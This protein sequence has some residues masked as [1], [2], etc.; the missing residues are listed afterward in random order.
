LGSVAI[1]AALLFGLHDSLVKAGWSAAT[2][3]RGLGGSAVVL[4]VWFLAAVALAWMG[5]YAADAKRPPRIE[6]GLLVPVTI[7]LVLLWRKSAFARLIGAVPQE[8]LVGV[9]VYR[10]LGAIFLI[11]YSM[12]KLPGVFAWPAGVGD[13]LVGV[14]APIVALAYRRAPR[15]K[16]SL[17]LAW[18]ILGLA[19]LVVAI[20]TGLLSS[21]SPIQ[22]LA[23]DAPNELI[24]TFPLALIPTF[25]VPISILLHVASLKRLYGEAY[26]RAWA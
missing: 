18:N 25:L 13:I 15:E 26:G 17:V 19:D 8:W 24:T 21:P 20:G 1:I 22:R 2:Y 9:Q 5:V 7:A 3:R 10:A 11:L 14:L 23:L 6:F 12:K 4:I 16:R